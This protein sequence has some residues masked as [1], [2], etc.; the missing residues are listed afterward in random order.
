V[1]GAWSGYSS[2]KFD[3]RTRTKMLCY[4]RRSVGQSLLVSS[5]HLRPN[6][7]FLLLSDS[8][9]FLDV[10]CPL[11]LEDMSVVY[12]CGWSSTAQSFS[13]PSPAGLMTI[14]CCLRFETPPTWRARSLYIPQGT[15]WPRHWVPL[16]IAS[17]DSQGYGEGTRTDLHTD[18]GLFKYIKKFSLYLREH[19]ESSLQR[20]IRQCC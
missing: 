4:D 16:S 9:R 20:L 13:G 6:T 2:E 7:R 10:S 1:L 5:P 8:C 14:F 19:T 11:W 18:S 15:G 3:H 12:N 17:Y